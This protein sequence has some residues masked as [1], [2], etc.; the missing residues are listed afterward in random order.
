MAPER[1]LF[2]HASN[3]RPATQ[4]SLYMSV[5]SQSSCRWRPKLCCRP[6]TGNG[7]FYRF[8]YSP[9]KKNT[10][11]SQ[12][13]RGQF[14]SATVVF[15]LTLCSVNYRNSQSDTIRAAE[16]DG[17]AVKMSGQTQSE[18]HQNKLIFT[19]GGMTTRETGVALLNASDVNRRL[20]LGLAIHHTTLKTTSLFLM[21]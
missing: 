6:N 16:G 14:N 3:K 10:L 13:K 5:W 11:R 8:S 7:S 15:P 19:E 12:N 20:M 1:V 9:R 4:I 18:L 21:P 2:L 17:W